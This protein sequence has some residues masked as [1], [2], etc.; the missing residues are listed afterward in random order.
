MEAEVQ[1][2][3]G[4]VAD[5]MERSGLKTIGPRLVKCRG[6]INVKWQL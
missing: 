5:N 4:L 3:D 1:L 2:S 6:H